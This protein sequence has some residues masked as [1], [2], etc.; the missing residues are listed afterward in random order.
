[1]EAEAALGAEAAA[2]RPPG[3]PRRAA[4][5]RRFTFGYSMLAPAVV[6]MVVLVGVPFFFSL[7]LS[8]SNAT[9]GNPVAQ[10]VGFRNFVAVLQDGTIRLALRNTIVF[11][12]IAG[13][14]KAVLGTLLAF[15]L[16]QAV[17]G[18]RL[19]RALVVLPW[20]LPVVITALAWKWGFDPQF[21]SVNW[22]ATHLHLLSGW[23]NWLGEPALAMAAVITVNV[24]R[25]FPFAAIVL[26]AGISAVP[27]ELLDSA[28]V[29]GAN[30][31][32][33]FH[34]VI[35]PITA[36][37]LFVGLL[38]DTVFT[39]T[40]ISIIYLLTMGGPMNTTEILPT[41]AFE[42]G[43]QAGALGRGAAISL[44]LFPLLL[45]IVYFLLRTLRRREAL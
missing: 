39:L 8:M 5:R 12:V 32:L 44:L 42:I 16:L 33:R 15:L 4:S 22:V 38:F 41:R 26:M 9:V 28:K 2:E 25:G 13:I 20:T 7:Y 21:S 37:I 31:F 43:I 11:T 30:F 1:M 29:D 10:F 14:C 34:Y 6:Y 18:R 17:P 3:I 40:D 27:L 24:W 36:P 23:P 19:I 45:P 35:V